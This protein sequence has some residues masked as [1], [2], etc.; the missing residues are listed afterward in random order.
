MVQEPP[1]HV[2]LVDNYLSL[3]RCGISA[4]SSTLA[5]GLASRGHTVTVYTEKR[6]R[7]KTV[8]PLN[9]SVAVRFYRFTDKNL[10][11]QKLREEIR[12]LNP[13][14]CVPLFPDSRHLTWAVT[15]LGSGVPFVYSERHSPETIEN[16][17]WSK[18][19]R[20]AALSGADRIHLQLS[21]FVASVP[22]HLQSRVCVINNP[23]P[24]VQGQ[25]DPVGGS[26]RKR[27]LWL[28]RFQ[29]E[30]KQCRVAIN[31]FASLANKHPDWDLHIAGDGPDKKLV[32]ACAASFPLK[33]RI[34]FHGESK[35]V[36]S[37]YLASQ[38]FCISSRTEGMPNTL[39]EA[40]ACGLP[41]VGF[42][43]CEGIPDL[44]VP[45]ENGLMAEEM[46]AA[47]LAKNLDILMSDAEARKRM[48][49]NARKVQQTHSLTAF[50]DAWEELLYDAAACKGNTV[51][52]EFSQE[53]FASMARLSS[54]ARREWL[55]R[56]FGDPFPGSFE[57]GF[58]YCISKLYALCLKI[59]L[60]L[61]P[62]GKR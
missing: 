6:F 59:K 26:G 47:C 57:H 22:D 19:G 13:D 52:D 2:V 46:T 35:D 44:I 3:M 36:F 32:H 30:T 55:W 62:L 16:V 4:I 54:M 12:T 18:K 9:E 48:G 33:G 41:S 28:A 38:L 5:N 40:L 27:L 50:M 39:L 37:H 17:F 42:A 23:A 58:E 61:L 14:V 10:R 8:Y 21:S 51:M 20:L 31:A 60:L 45:G 25:A 49:D 29:E 15:L 56:D 24:S 34:V 1:L 53:P 11:I 43:K 7:C